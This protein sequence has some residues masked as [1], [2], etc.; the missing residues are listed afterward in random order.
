VSTPYDHAINSFRYLS[1]QTIAGGKV[2]YEYQSQGMA[3]AACLC[4]RLLADTF[5]GS[6]NPAI[7]SPAKCVCR[8]IETRLI[9]LYGPNSVFSYILETLR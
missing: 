3:G 1:P 6:W 8:D 4:L 7:E 2:I 9:P 5:T